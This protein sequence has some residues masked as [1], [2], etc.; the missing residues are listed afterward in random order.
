MKRFHS[1]MQLI[2]IAVIVIA[3][4]LTMTGCFFQLTTTEFNSIDAYGKIIGNGSDRRAQEM[5]D[6][7][8]PEKIEDYFDEPVY[9]YI[10]QYGID[11]RAFEIALEF[12]IEDTETFNGFVEKAAAGKNCE[13]FTYDEA[14]QCYTITSPWI[15]LDDKAPCKECG[16][17][18][19]HYH[20]NSADI[21]LMLVQPDTQRIIFVGLGV[22]DG[23]GV[24]TYDLCWFFDRFSIDPLVY[25]A[26]N[27]WESPI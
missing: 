23:G 3:L 5:F 11:A 13:V 22:F 27:T 17:K 1:V 12:T 9:H 15:V 8:F 18:P 19:T 14:Y 16:T 10:A 6:E 7:M 25:E 26:E 24:D 4:L 20:I 2:G 21:E